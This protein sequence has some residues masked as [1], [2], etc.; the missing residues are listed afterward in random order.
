VKS[1][2][3]MLV[4]SGRRGRKS[5]TRGEREIIE[6]EEA[7][8]V[9]SWRK[10]LLT[11]LFTMPPASFERLCMRVL[12]ESGFIQVEVTGRTGTAGSTP[13]AWSDWSACSRSG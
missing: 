2:R 4:A 1:V 3:T 7:S 10:K 9:A 6:A 11:P 8:E 13:T 5:K 12:R